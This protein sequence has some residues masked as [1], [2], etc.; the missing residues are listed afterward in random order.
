MYKPTS[1]SRTRLLGAGAVFIVLIAFG[2]FLQPGFTKPSSLQTGDAEVVSFLTPLLK[3][4]RGS[5]AAALITPGGVK[6]GLW[7]SDY[8][9]QYEI[10]S[11]TKTMTA[12]L[13]MEAIQRGE[14]TRHTRISELVPEIK[15]KAR[16]I[17]LEELASHRSGLPPL[18]TS[19]RQ[20]TK[21]LSAIIMR[22]SFWNYDEATLIDMVN[23]ADL[24]KTGEFDYSNTGYA[25]LGLALERA[26]H[27]PFTSLL[28]ARVFSPAK[29]NGTVV[30]E[31]STP[32]T[33]AFSHG[34]SASGFPE[35]PWVLHAFTPAAG[36]RSTIVDMANYAQ[37]LLAGKLA[38]NEAMLPLFTTD[39]P[40]S[41][42]GYAWFTTSIKGQDIIWHDGE[43]SGFAT[44]I[45]FDRQQKTAV[46]ILSDTAWPVIGPAVRLLLAEAHLDTEQQ[47][48][49]D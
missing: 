24:Q 11:L 26:S 46:V 20:K 21:V 25:L 10:A 47:D 16:D 37:T 13:F 3:G 36:V 23:N 32:D 5:V 42:I 40:D 34:W 31:D 38:E 6:Y 18:A 7:N 30:A 27:Q 39:D 17:S 41:H 45:A 1:C 33:P 48:E 9:K 29:M 2:I 15:G 8:D 35:A 49:L 19:F 28:H 14:I 22:K 4:T 44:V 43:S 12:G